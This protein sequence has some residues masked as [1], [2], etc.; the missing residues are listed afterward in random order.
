[1]L[2][3]ERLICLH[4]PA[5]AIPRQLQAFQGDRADVAGIGKLLRRILVEPD[6][7]PGLPGINPDCESF[8]EEQAKGLAEQFSG[9]T[10]LRSRTLMNFVNLEL[11][12]PGFLDGPADL[13]ASR[14]VAARGL[15]E[16]FFFTG[17]V[18]C[19][20]RRVLNIAAADRGRHDSLAY[21]TQRVHS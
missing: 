15:S 11:P 17:D 7:I 5:V 9:P 4:H 18:P 10:R 1:M 6:L 2:P 19:E 14:V 3:G 21:R 12:R 16:M 20:L 13:L 8:L